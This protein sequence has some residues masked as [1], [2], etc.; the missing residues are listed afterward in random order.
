MVRAVRAEGDE[1]RVERLQL[2]PVHQ[3]ELLSLGVAG[4]E[5]WRGGADDAFD[6]GA[7][8]ER[9]RLHPLDYAVE[10]F[11]GA[12]EAVGERSELGRGQRA[13]PFAGLLIPEPAAPAHQAGADEEGGGQ[14][15]PFQDG[16]GDG[17]GVA[18][19]VIEREG[20][21]VDDVGL[22]VA[23]GYAHFAQDAKTQRIQGREINS[24]PHSFPP[25][26]PLLPFASSR[27]CVR[28][29]P[30]FPLHVKKAIFYQFFTP[31]SLKTLRRRGFKGEK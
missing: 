29:H 30:P 4:A 21:P 16:L 28:P 10:V 3:I 31:A 14:A 20:D 23:E 26:N 8:V 18:R 2:G 9:E 7:R 5:I 12:P 27:L 22:A 11:A 25:P 15:E 1:R 19:A 13:K 17:A 6:V 24:L